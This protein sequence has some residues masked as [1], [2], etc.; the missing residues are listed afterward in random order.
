MATYA[1]FE[2]LSLKGHAELNERWVQDRIAEDPSILGL[3]DLVLHG[4]CAMMGYLRH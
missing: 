3:G 1:K 4:D 2:T